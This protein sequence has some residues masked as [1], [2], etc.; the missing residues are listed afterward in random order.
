MQHRPV[1]W[2]GKTQYLQAIVKLQLFLGP[3]KSGVKQRQEDRKGCW[4][5]RLQFTRNW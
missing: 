5:S 3:E 4:E 2:A 1:S